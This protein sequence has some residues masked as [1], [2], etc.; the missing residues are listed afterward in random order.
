MEALSI[1]VLEFY[2]FATVVVLLMMFWI[3]VDICR[4]F[5]SQADKTTELLRTDRRICNHISEMDTLTK[6]LS[7]TRKQP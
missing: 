3:V 7:A 1:S 2:L 4:I 6:Q 5:K